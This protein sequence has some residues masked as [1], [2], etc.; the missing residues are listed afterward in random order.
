MGGFLLATSQ[1]THHGLS[2]R[3]PW[4][5]CPPGAGRGSGRTPHNQPLVVKVPLNSSTWGALSGARGARQ[6]PP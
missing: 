4:L 2:S 5:L 1:C 6:G 3:G